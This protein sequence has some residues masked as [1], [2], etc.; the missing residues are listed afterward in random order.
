MLNS[1][2]LDWL[3]DLFGLDLHVNH[4]QGPDGGV[5]QNMFLT[6]FRMFEDPHQP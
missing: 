4:F 3:L 6:F 2:S 1:Y 5:V